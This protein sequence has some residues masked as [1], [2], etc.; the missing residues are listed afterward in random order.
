M[1]KRWLLLPALLAF[2]FTLLLHAPAT[3]TYAWTLGANKGSN[4]A[5][6]GVNGTLA[7]GGFAALTI[8]QRPVLQDVEW[9]L[10]PAWLAVLRVTADLRSGGDAV[11]RVRVSRSLFGKLRMSGLSAAGSV[12]SLLQLAGQPPLPVSG[13]A[14]LDFARLN[15]DKGLPVEAEG[16]VEIEDLNWTL[17]RD[18]LPLGSFNAALTT[19]KQG[20]LVNFGSGPGPLELGGT[21]TLNGER[22]YDLNLQLRPR[23][24]AG[25]QLLSLLRSLGPPDPQGWYHLRRKGA[26][27]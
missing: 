13:Q 20:I 21:A 23:P 2:L 27:S 18:P 25:A 4:L 26:L 10:Q 3:L 16:S 24:E 5:L 19:D 7:H 14:R 9:T 1:Q 22:A 6:Y 15:L 11:A 12:K 17:A 8:N